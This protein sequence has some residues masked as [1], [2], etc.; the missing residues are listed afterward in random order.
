MPIPDFYV[1]LFEK[2]FFIIYMYS[3]KLLNDFGRIFSFLSL[4]RFHDKGPSL[5]YVRV[6]VKGWVGGTAKYLLVFLTGV[7][8][9]FG[10]SLH[11]KNK[12]NDWYFW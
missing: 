11:K 1:E 8:G 6:R 2:F 5:Y 10:S 9:G 4:L 3:K 7:G 12:V